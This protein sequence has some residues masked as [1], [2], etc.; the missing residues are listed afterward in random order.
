V[1]HK[2]IFLTLLLLIA[3]ATLLYSQFLGNP[4]VFDDLPFFYGNNF[5]EA[6]AKYL[7]KVFSLDLRWLPYASFVWT[8]DLIGE[9]L[10]W[11]HLGN[12]ILHLLTVITLFL[13][14]RRLF[15]LVLP[16]TTDKNYWLAFFAA[17]IF[18]VHPVSVYAVAYLSQRTMLMATL[19]TLLSWRFFIEGIIR[20]KQLWLLASVASYFLAVVSKEH[21]IMAPAVAIVLL[22]LL[23]PTPKTEIRRVLPAFVLYGL[24]GLFVIIQIK[25]RHQIGQIYEPVGPDFILRLG[26][27]FDPRLVYP[28]S[29]LTQS[30]LFF[31]YL[32]VWIIPT[33]VLMSVD[34]CQNFTT[35]F[36]SFKELAAFLAFVAYPVVAWRL[37]LQKG[38]NGL[39]GFALLC[40]WLM[41]AT[42]ISTVRIQEAF[43][44]YR[45]YIWMVGFFAC[46]P[47]LCQKLS[48]KQSNYALLFIALLM[49]PLALSRLQTFSH[50]LLLWD[51]AN[52]IVKDKWTCPVI[53][54][55]LNNRGNEFIAISRYSEAI[56]DFSVAIKAT[57]DG[58]RQSGNDPFSKDN[59]EKSAIAPQRLA[60]N[61][62]N[63]GLAYLKSQ[64][65][66]EALT[67]F[68][69]AITLIPNSRADTWIGKAQALAGL[70][71]N[72]AAL[73]IYAMVCSRGSKNAC[74]EQKELEAKL[75]Q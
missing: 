36:W 62:H 69:K 43:V 48:S 30:F 54:R 31:K 29:V 40:P 72:L 75:K 44:L 13:L 73:E 3:P 4:L 63:R 41:F 42:E 9:Q 25:L 32:W 20:E 15:D 68:S 71:Q 33:P 19:F 45:S 26:S 56:E 39:L 12:L 14:L 18:S 64:H 5:G 58:Y 11:L 50:P 51:D 46:V 37:V 22:V 67:D 49:V 23:K 8:R 35:H 27:D 38:V 60:I 66:A 7:N 47:F 24:I 6:Y 70:K 1:T 10:I 53:G 28:L 59:K 65:Y 17:L 2:N 61:Y 16:N 34:I 74:K 55:I 52:R 21:A 57:E